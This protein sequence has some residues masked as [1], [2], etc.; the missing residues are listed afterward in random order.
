MQFPLYDYYLAS[1]MTLEQILKHYIKYFYL[2]KYGSDKAEKVLY[3]VSQSSK[4]QK[5]F[6]QSASQGIAPNYIDFGSVINEIMYFMFQSNETQALAVLAAAIAWDKKVN[7]FETLKSDYDLRNDAIKIFRKYSIYGDMPQDE[8]DTMT[9]NDL[10]DGT[11]DSTASNTDSVSQDSNE[12]KVRQM[13]RNGFEDYVRK[14]AND[15]ADILSDPMVGG[16]ML[17]GAVGSYYQSLKKEQNLHVLASKMGI[18][19]DAILDEECQRVLNKY[20]E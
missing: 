6:D 1:E 12:G 5:L 14:Y 3:K 9:H 8:Y 10:N 7:H 20:L 19:I 16:I 11:D 15:N 2:R 4:M 13:I 17:Q 18:D